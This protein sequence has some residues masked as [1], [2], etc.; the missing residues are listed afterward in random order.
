[1]KNKAVTLLMCMLMVASTAPVSNAEGQD[2][3]SIWGITYDWSHF[4]GDAFNM[5]GVDVN[6]LNR[7]LK[8][9]A[10]YAGFDLDYD[11]VK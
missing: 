3:S 11:Q 5:T 9:A 1:M 10:S 6:E 7:D 8:E 2:E 4:E